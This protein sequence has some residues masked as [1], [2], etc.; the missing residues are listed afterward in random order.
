MKRILALLLAGIP[1]HAAEWKSVAPAKD[2]AAY[3]V[4]A[5]KRD[6]PGCEFEDG[7]SE[8]R[9]SII[10]QDGA[11]W[12]RVA[13]AAGQIGPDNGGAGWRWPWPEKSQLRAELRF[14]VLFEPGFEWVKGGKLPGLCGGPKTITG[15]DRCTGLEGWSA[16]LMWRADGRGQAYVYHPN[17]KSKYGDEFDFPADFRFPTGEPVA[18]RLEV[19]INT[20]GNRDGS[21]R[22]WVALRRQPERLVVEQPAM[23][24][25]KAAG[26]GVDSILFHSFH[27]G[28]GADWAPAYSCAARFGHIEY[29]VLQLKQ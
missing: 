12:W 14:S 13:F 28:N 3:D 10:R 25:R 1:A 16:R 17:M 9:V 15:G 21:L 23:E 27:G 18:V 2:A 19:G 5:W 22:V 6:W 20:I 8:G 4:A 11:Q 26:I 7:V 29:R 24:W